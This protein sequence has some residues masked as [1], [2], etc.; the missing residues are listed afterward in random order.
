MVITFPTFKKWSRDRNY[1]AVNKCLNVREREEMVMR[2]IWSHPFLEFFSTCKWKSSVKE[3]QE[4]KS[5]LF[6][7]N[8]SNF[9]FR[10]LNYHENENNNRK[11]DNLGFEM[12][13]SAFVLSSQQVYT[14]KIWFQLLSSV[15][16]S[17]SWAWVVVLG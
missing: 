10:C 5:K 3:K 16:E 9:H 2:E 15:P 4:Y 8:I 6:L 12:K 1:K 14:Y 13:S 11:T 17:S 7:L